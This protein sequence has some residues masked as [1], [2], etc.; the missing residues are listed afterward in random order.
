[1]FSY[2][3]SMS[4]QRDL[5]FVI[6]AFKQVSS[7]NICLRLYVDGSPSPHSRI[8]NHMSGGDN[9]IDDRGPYA[10]EQQ[11]EVL[12]EA[13]VILAPS[14]GNGDHAVTHDALPANLPLIASNEST[15]SEI[16]TH[17]VTGFTFSAGNVCDLSDVFVNVAHDPEI[18][19]LL[20]DNISQMVLPRVEE[21]AY[22]YARLY[23]SARSGRGVEGWLC[24]TR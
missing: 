4:R 8:V 11:I 19:N 24:G 2:V 5:D 3:G 1:M 20:K 16:L 12:L 21:E 9:R 22:A 15:V 13:D 17:G 6:T 23:T 18:L 7:P 14:S 10:E